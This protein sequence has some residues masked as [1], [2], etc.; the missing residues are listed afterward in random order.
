MSRFSQ[1]ERSKPSY[2]AEDT[3][4]AIA[5]GIGGAVSVVRVSGP[6]ALE[7]LRLL[8]PNLAASLTPRLL[9]L[10]PLTD[11][12]ARPIDQAL[13]VF[14]A[15][16][17]SYTG[18]DVVEYHLH[19][20]S[21][22]APR[23][24]E[25][26]ASL[27]VRQSLPGE[28]SFR[29]VRNG[30][31]SL[32]QAQAVADLIK[33][34]HSSAVELALEKLSGTEHNLLNGI[35]DELRKLAALCEAGIDFTDQE[36]DPEG[37]TSVKKLQ[38]PL[39]PILSALSSLAQSFKRGTR[40]QEGIPVALI[41]TPNS[42][43]STFFNA[44]LGEERALVSEIPGTTRDLLREP[45]TL[46][47]EQ[48]SVCLR[49]ED[50]AGLRHSEDPVEQMG[51]QRSEKAA[52]SA[53][54]ILFL[55]DPTQPLDAAKSAFA[56]FKNHGTKTIAVVTKSDLLRPH[57][58]AEKQT[59]LDRLFSELNISASCTISAKTGD[60]LAQVVEIITNYCSSLTLRSKGEV[61][62]TRVDHF[63][64]VRAAHHHLSRAQKTSAQDLFAADIRQALH[65]L[66]PLIGETSSEDLLIRIFSDF[67]IGK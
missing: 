21:Q 26:L 33:A 39:Q 3:I 52:E 54:L 6:R 12:Q 9:Y 7:T 8:S 27:G 18:E 19:G 40:I 24:I 64:A 67:C 51:V 31:M 66:G 23:L 47:G 58:R 65:A 48:Q 29:A 11:P 63:E 14:F 30:K 49:L 10:A 2:F 38:K 44:L 46:Q 41:G 37:V 36:I 50:T 35:A 60:G 53:E 5:S 4:A 34:T 62:L 22:I 13:C 28:F 59:Q 45:L 56:P 17:A 57:E 55:V 25:T 1:P 43:K 61:V 42:G 20:G 32:T 16:P 15:G